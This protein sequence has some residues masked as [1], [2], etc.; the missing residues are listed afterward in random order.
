MPPRGEESLVEKLQRQRI[1][2]KER[3]ALAMAEMEAWRKAKDAEEAVEAP[4]APVIGI[5]PNPMPPLD[6]ATE[7]ALRAS[8]ERFG[9]I[10]PVVKDQH[11]RILDGHHRA[12]IAAELGVP[13]PEQVREIADGDDALEIAVSLNADRRQMTPDQRREIVSAL[14]QE[15][16]SQRAIADAV[17]V[18]KRT[19][20]KDIK[21]QVATGSHLEESAR[22]ELPET[23]L[24]RDGKEYPAARPKKTRKAR[25]AKPDVQL[26]LFEQWAKPTKRERYKAAAD[27]AG[28]TLDEWAE[29]TLDAACG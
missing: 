19:V 12:R 2:A 26:S 24:G 27:D 15:G 20:E 14:R 9:V 21:A 10:V 11:G 4:P 8:I 5:L 17:G 13:C 1:E 6:T 7:A 18:S 23:T 22:P 28:Y 25:K 3:T 29:A 16:H